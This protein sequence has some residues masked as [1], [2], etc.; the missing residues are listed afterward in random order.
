MRERQTSCRLAMQEQWADEGRM[1]EARIPMWCFSDGK[2]GYQQKPSQPWANQSMS[3]ICVRL[4]TIA[5]N[6]HCSLIKSLLSSSACFIA[7]LK[8]KEICN[9]P[10]PSITTPMSLSQSAAS[11]SNNSGVDTIMPPAQPAYHLPVSPSLASLPCTPAWSSQIC[12]AHQGAKNTDMSGTITTT[13]RQTTDEWVYD[14]VF[15]HRANA[16]DHLLVGSQHAMTVPEMSAIAEA[17]A[18]GCAITDIVFEVLEK[19]QQQICL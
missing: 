1:K 6:S 7:L 8:L 3:A 17:K 15:D 18:L 4:T 14:K 10:L 5:K 9:W 19:F 2:R 12:C 13:A 11:S 16:F